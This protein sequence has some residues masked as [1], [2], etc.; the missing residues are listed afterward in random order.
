MLISSLLSL[1]YI[2]PTN[3]DIKLLDNNKNLYKKI[4]VKPNST[5]KLLKKKIKNKYIYFDKNLNLIFSN[6]F[7]S[8]DIFYDNKYMVKTYNSDIIIV[9][10]TNKNITVNIYFV[11]NK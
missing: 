7:K 9:N 11:N 1:Y 4:T 8:S 5:Y 10:N 6:I 2:T 3:Y